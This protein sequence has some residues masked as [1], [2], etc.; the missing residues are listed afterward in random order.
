M[1][2]VRPTQEV[3]CVTCGKTFEGWR[4]WE[5]T[6]SDE[7]HDIEMSRIQKIRNVRRKAKMEPKNE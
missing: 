2:I 3:V 5:D 7:C 1:R 4:S 6:C